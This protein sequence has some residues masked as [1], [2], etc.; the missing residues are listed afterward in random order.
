MAGDANSTKYRLSRIATSIDDQTL[1]FADRLVSSR[2]TRSARARF[3]GRAKFIRPR[4]IAGPTR[5]S[6]ARL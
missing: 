2:N 3:Q 5:A 4:W 1:G 6:N